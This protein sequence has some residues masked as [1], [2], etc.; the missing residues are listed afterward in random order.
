MKTA[1]TEL[2]LVA[3]QLGDAKKRLDEITWTSRDVANKA[4]GEHL[5]AINTSI[6]DAANRVFILTKTVW[7]REKG[8]NNAA[9]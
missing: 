2:D 4:V 7:Q 3:K 6:D 9:K 1:I 8:G 5:T